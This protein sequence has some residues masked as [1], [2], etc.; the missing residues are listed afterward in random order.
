[1]DWKMGVRF[2]KGRFLLNVGLLMERSAAL[3]LPKAT[4]S[5]KEVMKRDDNYDVEMV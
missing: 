2:R 1:M 4:I 5:G 3:G